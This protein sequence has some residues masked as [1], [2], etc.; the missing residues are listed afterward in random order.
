MADEA[1]ALLESLVVTHEMALQLAI[2]AFENSIGST[3]QLQTSDDPVVY[4]NRFHLQK[5]VLGGAGLGSPGAM[6]LV[7]T[8]SAACRLIPAGCFVRRRL[9]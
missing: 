1:T 5:D 4:T 3:A 8:G 6:L 7:H 9:R 2:G